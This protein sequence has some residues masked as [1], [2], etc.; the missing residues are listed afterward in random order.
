[1]SHP[2]LAKMQQPIPSLSKLSSLSCES[3]QLRKHSYS[4]LP[5]NVSQCA[6]LFALIHSNILGLSRVQSN[7]GFQYLVTFIDDYSRCTWLFFNKK[8]F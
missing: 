5:S 3:C 1:M 4:S 2:S 7:L 6:F 8:S